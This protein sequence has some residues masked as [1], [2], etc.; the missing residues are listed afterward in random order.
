MRG[1]THVIL[2]Y[3]HL[4]AL[5]I[6]PTT[7]YQGC[8]SLNARRRQEV[9]AM[10]VTGSMPRTRGVLS[11]LLLIL[12]GAWG[13]LAPFVGPY[14]HYAYT[15]D[16]TWAYTSGRL[17]LEVA[18]GLAAVLGGLV[19]L[20]SRSRVVGGLFAFL[21]AL[22]G[23]WFVAGAAI[24]AQFV[25]NGSINPGVPVGAAAGGTATSTRQFLEG[26]G[27]FTGTGVLIVF[28][29]ALA[30]GRFT[31]AATADS[32]QAGDQ[33][34]WTGRGVPAEQPEQDRYAAAHEDYPTMTSQYPPGGQPAPSGPDQSAPDQS[35]HSREQFPAPTGQVPAP[36][37]TEQFPAAPGQS[38]ASTEQ[39]PSAAPPD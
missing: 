36:T 32:S 1:R 35:Q 26:L 18:P 23:A 11:G 7:G 20:T 28:F 33:E 19:V 37:P 31:L 5:C 24:T 6:S 22:G 2:F 38:P 16:R 34:P 27:F 30:L 13:A 3:A 17:W 12:L 25:R 8:A 21:A 14:F 15:P 10:A 39:A 29:A 4:P 9:S